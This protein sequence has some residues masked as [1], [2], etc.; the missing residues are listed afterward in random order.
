MKSITITHDNNAAR[1]I[2]VLLFKVQLY[3]GY[4][5]SVVIVCLIFKNIFQ[6]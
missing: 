1:L 5:F 2:I 3:V 6:C 4:Y